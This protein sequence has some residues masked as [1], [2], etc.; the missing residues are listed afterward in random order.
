MFQQTYLEDPKY[1]T[2]SDISFCPSS[3][4]S[5]NLPTSMTDL[6][7]CSITGPGKTSNNKKYE[8]F[9]VGQNQDFLNK[10]KRDDIFGFWLV[11]F[12]RSTRY[13]R[14]TKQH[15][16]KYTFMIRIQFTVLY[17]YLTTDLCTPITFN[18]SSIK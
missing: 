18:S 2:I 10:L 16:I 5:L 13:I 6:L 4:M 15:R 3:D 7:T 9:G 12:P 8:Q 1:T 11:N 17:I 14:Q